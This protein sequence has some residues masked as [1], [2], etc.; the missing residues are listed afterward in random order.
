MD[1]VRAGKREEAEDFIRDNNFEMKCYSMSEAKSAADVLVT[2]M[3]LQI[4]V[5]QFVF[6]SQ[7]FSFEGWCREID[8]L[9]G[10][11]QGRTGGG[12]G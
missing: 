1:T 5:K 3:P 10:L 6:Q 8:R 11:V 2:G 9:T 12:N 7:H 4:P